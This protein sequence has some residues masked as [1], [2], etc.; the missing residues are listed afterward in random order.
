MII[1]LKCHFRCVLYSA[2]LYSKVPIWNDP[3]ALDY[4]YM[5]LLCVCIY[6]Y[7]YVYM[8]ACVHRCMKACVYVCLCLAVYEGCVYMYVRM[9]T[10]L[11]DTDECI[12]MRHCV[13]TLHALQ[14]L[15]SN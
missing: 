2:Y 13:L 14:T 11:I 7:A 3:F 10:G 4:L 6:T 9:N 5:A 12:C 15:L 1:H 8:Y